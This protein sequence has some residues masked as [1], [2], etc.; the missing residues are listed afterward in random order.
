[1]PG[2][3]WRTWCLFRRIGSIVCARSA[4]A[5]DDLELELAY[6]EQRLIVDPGDI[7]ASG[8]LRAARVRRVLMGHKPRIF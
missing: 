6:L 3:R 7:E 2:C 4:L 8:A 1:M 5:P